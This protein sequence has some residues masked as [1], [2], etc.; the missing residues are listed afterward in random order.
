M[1]TLRNTQC[2]ASTAIFC[3][4][5]SGTSLTAAIKGRFYK[6]GLRQG[7]GASQGYA[8]QGYGARSCNHVFCSGNVFRFVL[9]T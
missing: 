6:S 5:T 9:D 7:Y 4:L 8:S 3:L 2:R 1:F